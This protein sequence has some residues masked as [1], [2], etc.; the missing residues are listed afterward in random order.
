MAQ[1]VSDCLRTM[2]LAIG[3]RNQNDPDS[4]DA[5]LLQYINDFVNL[6]MS[7]DVKLFEN[8]GTLTFTIDQTN[9]TGVYTFNEVGASSSFT[10]ISDE[11]FI[12][13][14]S[15]PA[16][17]ISWNKLW[18]FQDPGPF[19]AAW[20]INNTDVLIPGYPTELLYYGDQLVFRTIPNQSYLVQI[21]GY[22]IIDEFA[23]EGDPQLPFDYW[24]RYIA[25]GAAMNYARDYRFEA[26]KI[27]LLDAAFGHERK[28]VLTRTHNQIKRV[29]GFPRF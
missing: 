9:P 11:A 14:T 16:G 19:Y 15:P 7:E 12:S 3:R 28:Q 8:F 10:N 26:D 25:Y 5:T 24:M 27:Q 2:R 29:R 21:Y 18:I 4:N 22:K 23:S 17:S 20:G 1:F 13:I 6:T